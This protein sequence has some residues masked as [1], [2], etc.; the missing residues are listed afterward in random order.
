MPLL[1]TDLVE[2]IEKI[3]QESL[4]KIEIEWYNNAAV[5]V[6]LASGGYPGEYAKGKPVFGL[7]EAG[8]MK[9]VIVFHAGTAP[10]GQTVVTSGGRVLGVTGLGENI[11]A[12]I[13]TAY[14]AV[15]KISFEGMHYRTDIARR[16]LR[17]YEK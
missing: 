17:H 7:D 15:R 6:V 5:C 14:A 13:T 12:A 11:S 16:A 2:I 10:A 4:D 8:R 3:N 9:D 1:K